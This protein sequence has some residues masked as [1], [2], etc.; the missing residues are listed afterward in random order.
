MA[1]A[2]HL[3]QGRHRAGDRHL[4]F[5]ETRDNLQH[6]GPMSKVEAEDLSEIFV[7]HA[8][9]EHLVD[10]GE[11]RMNYATAG[12]P[13]LPALLLIPSQ[14]E[15]WWGHELVMPLLAEHFQVFASTSAARGGQHG[16]LV[17]TRWTTWATT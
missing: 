5:Y 14:T 6:R 8:F 9:E 2:Q 4:K 16:P 7:S 1:D 12:D 10:L 15:S 11:V 3:P 17:A 13:D